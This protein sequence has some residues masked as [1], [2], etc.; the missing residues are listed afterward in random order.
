M[1]FIEARIGGGML[2]E[3]ASCLICQ[4]GDIEANARLIAAAPLML[5]ELQD[6]CRMVFDYEQQE[7]SA[8]TLAVY[9][10]MQIAK[11]TQTV[12]AKATGEAA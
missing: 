3:V 12:I 2:Q 1:K 7:I 10:T 5:K 8:D 9:M 4:E 11:H 6:I